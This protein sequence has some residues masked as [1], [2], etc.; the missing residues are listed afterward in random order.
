MLLTVTGTTKNVTVDFTPVGV[1]MTRHLVY[2]A[3]DNSVVHRKR[4]SNGICS[5]TAPA[6]KT[7]KNNVMVTVI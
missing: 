1:K 2:R 6:G 3:A 7:I 4:V 5:L